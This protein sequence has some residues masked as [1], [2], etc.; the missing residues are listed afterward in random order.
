MFKSARECKNS[1][2]PCT[3][4][5]HPPLF[6]SRSIIYKE[7]HHADSPIHFA[8]SIPILKKVNSQACKS[9]LKGNKHDIIRSAEATSPTVHPRDG[10]PK[11]ESRARCLEYAVNTS[12]YAHFLSTNIKLSLGRDIKSNLEKTEILLRLKWRIHQTLFGE[13]VIRS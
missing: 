12:E 6:K 3:V 1:P 2:P 9:E 13:I 7:I 11:S 10:A 5:S 4:V 8:S